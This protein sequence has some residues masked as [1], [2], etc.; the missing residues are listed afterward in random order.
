MSDSSYRYEFFRANDKTLK[1]VARTR[2]KLDF[3]RKIGKNAK[4]LSY[5]GHRIKSGT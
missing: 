1:I 3:L 4:P 2:K 5:G